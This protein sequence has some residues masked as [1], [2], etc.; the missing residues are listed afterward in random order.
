[1]IFC[2]EKTTA[3]KLDQSILKELI[4][5]EG[6]VIKMKRRQKNYNELAVDSDA[7]NNVCLLFLSCLYGPEAS[8]RFL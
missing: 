3:H 6:K 5:H 8:A 4:F 7:D 2:S 1:M